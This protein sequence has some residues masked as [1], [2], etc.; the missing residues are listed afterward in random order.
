MAQSQALEELNP[1]K[2]NDIPQPKQIWIYGINDHLEQPVP[3]KVVGFDATGVFRTDFAA[4]CEK[5][6]IIPHTT[7]GPPRKAYEGMDTEKLLSV[8]SVLLDRVSMQ[9]AKQLIPT[10]LHLETIRFTS[11]K[12]DIDMLSLLRAGIADTCTIQTLQVEWN[13]LEVQL[14]MAQLKSI[15]ELSHEDLDEL[16]RDRDKKDAERKLRMFRELIT[17]T[18]GTLDAAF[19][20]LEA[21]RP[22]SR[23]GAAI[24]E[25]TV[26]QWNDLFRG[27]FSQILH[28]KYACSTMEQLQ[29]ATTDSTELFDLLDGLHFGEGNG[30]LSLRKVKDQLDPEKLPVLTEEQEAADPIAAA[31]A[32]F[33]N[34]TSVLENVSFRYCDLGRIEGR[35]IGEALKTNMHLKALNLYGN[36]ICDQGVQTIAEALETNLNYALRYLGLGRNR[37]TQEGLK[38]LCKAVGA[39]RI[40]SE[41]A[42]ELQK[43]IDADKPKKLKAFQATPPKKDATGRERHQLKECHFDEIVEKVEEDGEPYYLWYRNVE[44]HTLNLEQNPISDME[45]VEELRPYGVGVLILTGTPVAKKVLEEEERKMKEAAKEAEASG[46]PAP[47]AEEKE[48]EKPAEEEPGEPQRPNAWKIHYH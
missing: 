25:L 1:D 17:D 22:V 45:V 37:I 19:E 26:A 48:E 21:A 14:D 11:C 44:F 2:E 30:K 47:I 33:V 12:L 31:F 23:G 13:P 41:R 16:E 24:E 42:K 10:S 4:L 15:S 28:Q 38:T 18:W 34:G 20:A 5:Y 9:L 46:K 43:G 32:Q 3:D 36:R 6:G 40:D 8:S 39:Q 27:A 29:L 7:L 35:Q